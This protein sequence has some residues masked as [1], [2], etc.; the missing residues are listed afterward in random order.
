MDT[1][2]KMVHAVNN[3]YN[4][5]TSL[6]TI[7]SYYQL[8]LYIRSILANL[9]D[10]LSYIRSVSIHI[11]DYIDAATTGTFSPHI[12]PI[13]YLNQMLSH[14]EETLPTTMH[15]PVSSEDTLHYYRYLC[16]HILIAN[17]QFLLLT[18]VPILDHTQQLSIYNYLTLDI[19]HGNFTAWYDV[20]TQYL[21]VTQ[22]ETMAVEISQHQFHICQEANGQFCNVYAPQQPL[23]NH[24]SC[25]T[26]LYA[27]NAASISTRCSLQVRKTQSISIPLSIAPNV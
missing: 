24:P 2:G 19:P 13:T 1:V 3:L 27:K 10:S 8:V 20:S 17:R 7:L 9:Q 5:T 26:A 15:L 16:T 18:D 22:D 14:I 12:L 11:M 21:G 4:I 6:S 25:I 23:A